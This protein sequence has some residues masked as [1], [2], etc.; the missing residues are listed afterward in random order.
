VSSM[1]VWLLDVHSLGVRS[2]SRAR[3][4]LPFA[5]LERWPSLVEGARLLS[6]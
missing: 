6:E 5:I 4:H 3:Y 2:A 1:A